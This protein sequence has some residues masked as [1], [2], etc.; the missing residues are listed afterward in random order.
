MEQNK[1]LKL[2]FLARPKS[3]SMFNKLLWWFWRKWNRWFFRK[4]II[5]TRADMNHA[6]EIFVWYEEK[7]QLSNVNTTIYDS[8]AL[9]KTERR[10]V[11]TTDG[12]KCWYGLFCHLIL[13]LQKISNPIVL[14]RRTTSSIDTVLLFRWISVNGRKRIYC[15]KKSDRGGMELKMGRR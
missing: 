9:S 3:Q 12:K 13:M 2:I 6:S 7:K 5:A 10:Y 15:Q 4:Y 14:P 8:L 1:Y 11:T